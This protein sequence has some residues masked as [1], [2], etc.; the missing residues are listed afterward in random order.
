MI[1]YNAV[2]KIF[3]FLVDKDP[4]L[5]LRI[6]EALGNNET[7]KAIRMIEMTHSLRFI[8]AVQIKLTAHGGTVRT[9][10]VLYLYERGTV[11]TLVC[12]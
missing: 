12:S 6:F 11:L 10:H 5:L 8:S 7:V 2:R 4:V 9:V 1:F 3:C